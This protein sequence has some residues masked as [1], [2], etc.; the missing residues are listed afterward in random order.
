M[1]ICINSSC[2]NEPPCSLLNGYQLFGEILSILNWALKMDWQCKCDISI[3]FGVTECRCAVD[4]GEMAW[5]HRSRDPTVAC[6]SSLPTLYIESSKVVND[7]NIPDICQGYRLWGI[8][9]SRLCALHWWDC[10]AALL[11]FSHLAARSGTVNVFI[12]LQVRPIK[13]K[14]YSTEMPLNMRQKSKLWWHC[15][16]C[17]T[18]VTPHG[19][20]LTVL[21]LAPPPLLAPIQYAGLL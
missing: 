2:G 5:R 21:Y 19:L 13:L 14:W 1:N 3:W 20:W 8:C 17:C 11:L 7:E 16:G 15:I 9:L 6:R 4:D 10:S 12:T 18:S